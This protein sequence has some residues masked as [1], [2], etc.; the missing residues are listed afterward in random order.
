VQGQ[1]LDEHGE[2][3]KG[4]GSSRSRSVSMCDEHASQV[5]AFLLEVLEDARV[6]TLPHPHASA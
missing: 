4:R 2:R 3:V 6:G 5:L 1:A